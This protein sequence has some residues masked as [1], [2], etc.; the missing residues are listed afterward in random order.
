MLSLITL[1][2][3]TWAYWDMLKV[4]KSET[5][6]IGEGRI[7]VKAEAV[8]PAGKTLVP[9]GVIMGVTDIDEINL[10]YKVK[11][12][13]KLGENLSLSVTIENK[14]I[15]GDTTYSNL[16]NIV[17][18]TYQSTDINS[19]EQVITVTISLTEPANLTEYNAI[20]NKNITFDIVF[21][22]ATA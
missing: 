22:G 1:V 5:I 21:T 8:V 11:T 4:T 12:S 2:G 20:V 13:A 7:V 17:V 9:A 10:T 18:G 15:G 19:S 14:E 3:A 6:T 16:V